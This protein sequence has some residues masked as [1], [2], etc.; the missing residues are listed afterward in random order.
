MRLPKYIQFAVFAVA[1][2]AAVSTT[3]S[4]ATAAGLGGLTRSFKGSAGAEF[5]KARAPTLAPFAHVMFCMQNPGE[6]RSEG[7]S[8]KV[9]ELTTEKRAVL[10]A[11]NQRVN[12][13]IK[14]R[15]DTAGPL[16]DTW[17]L[18]PREGDCEDYA[19][20]KRHVLMSSGWP[21]SALRLAVVRTASGEGH[22][23]LVVRTSEGDLVL[24]NRT[25]AVRS[26]KRAG[27]R[28]L[29]IQS[30]ENPRTWYA[31]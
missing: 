13:S 10:M 31:L 15:Y 22:T 6:C 1:A 24:D 3:A 11:V 2:L 21:A 19:I 12:R 18:A 4:V 26:W 5:I 27:L 8:A 25:A 7:A 17:S 20:T 16:G 28:W 14:P 23:V 9:V 29:K 30:A